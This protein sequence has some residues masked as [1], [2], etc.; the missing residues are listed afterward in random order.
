[1]NNNLNFEQHEY[2]I[3]YM[4]VSMEFLSLRHYIYS[5]ETSLATRREERILYLKASLLT[6]C[7][8]ILEINEC[9]IARSYHMV[10]KLGSVMQ[11][12]IK[13]LTKVDFVSLLSQCMYQ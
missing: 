4:Y 7:K 13:F 5:C 10:I 3:N 11:Q 8:K 9:R 2:K 1:M 12:I 6:H